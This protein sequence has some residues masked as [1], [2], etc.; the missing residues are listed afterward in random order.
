MSTILNL[1]FENAIH[2]PLHTFE[3]MYLLTGQIW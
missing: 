1:D 2:P 3:E